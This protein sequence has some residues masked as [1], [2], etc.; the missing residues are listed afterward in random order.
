VVLS[1]NNLAVLHLKKIAIERKE[2]RW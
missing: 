2:K 1:E